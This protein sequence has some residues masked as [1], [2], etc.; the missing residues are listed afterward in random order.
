MGAKKSYATVVGMVCTLQGTTA[1]QTAAG[2][3]G[4]MGVGGYVYVYNS[5]APNYKYG[6]NRCM[7]VFTEALHKLNA[8]LLVELMWSRGQLA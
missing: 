1:L 6:F 2:V 7:Q 8:P 5:T 3:I 4:A